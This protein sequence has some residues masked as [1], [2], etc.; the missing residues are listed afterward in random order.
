MIMSTS[1]VVQ[2][3]WNGEGESIFGTILLVLFSCVLVAITVFR[4]RL[5]VNDQY[6]EGSMMDEAFPVPHLASV[7]SS[8]S[9]NGGSIG[10]HRITTTSSTRGEGGKREGK[11]TAGLGLWRRPS[12]SRVLELFDHSNSAVE[13]GATFQSL[14]VAAGSDI[15][16][17]G[18]TNTNTGSLGARSNVICSGTTDCLSNL[19]PDLLL[20]IIKFMMPVDIGALSSVSR[21]MAKDCK[22]D[23]IWEQLWLQNYASLWE[24]PKI[25]ELQVRRG[26]SWSPVLRHTSNL[27]I[28]A[29]S[30]PPQQG[31]FVFYLEFEAC[32]LE[33]L[34]AGMCTPDLCVL[35][36]GGSI[37]DI[38]AFLPLHPGSQE[39][40]SDACGG[41]ATEHFA[42]IGHSSDAVELARIYCI[43]AMPEHLVC[44]QYQHT[45]RLNRHS[46]SRRGHVTKFQSTMK[47]EQAVAVVNA[48]LGERQRVQLERLQQQQ[49]Q[50]QE[51]LNL[52]LNQDMGR[53][54]PGVCK[55]FACPRD[56]PHLGRARACYDPLLQKWLVW[57][58]CCGAVQAAEGLP[59]AAGRTVVE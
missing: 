56:E 58:T 45:D 3:G 57:W 4:R 16:F 26:I 7:S 35:G 25:R 41:D 54:A 33:W 12:F 29:R 30:S 10:G 48:E 22:A 6:R 27:D 1:E 2:T 59:E 32:W 28:S 55:Y 38:T 20:S 31:W 5:S 15:F 21:S 51:G 42:D 17:G 36:L 40:L 34:L 52:N 50:Q 13:K 47:R 8:S 39:T 49:Q 37:Y 46:G 53:I 24:N 14:I 43:H 9:S 11:P 19:T 23:F 18:G 44:G